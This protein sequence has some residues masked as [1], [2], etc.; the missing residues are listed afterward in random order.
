MTNTTDD[1]FR[2]SSQKRFKVLVQQTPYFSIQVMT[3]M[4]ERLRRLP[5]PA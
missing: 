5:P 4:A 1:L 3:N 2:L